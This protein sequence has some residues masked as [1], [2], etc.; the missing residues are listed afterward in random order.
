MAYAD[1]TAF[2]VNT[3]DTVCSLH[4]FKDTSVALGQ[5]ELRVNKVI[6]MKMGAGFGHPVDVESVA[7]VKWTNEWKPSSSND[8]P[9]PSNNRPDQ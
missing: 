5:N 3:S 4:S 7:Q 1:D 9:I 2:L 6:T 8:P